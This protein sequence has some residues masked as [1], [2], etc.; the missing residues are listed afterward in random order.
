MRL[1]SRRGSRTMY[2][3]RRLHRN[4]SITISLIGISPRVTTIGSMGSGNIFFFG[5]SPTT[6]LN[7]LLLVLSALASGCTSF[8]GRGVQYQLDPQYAVSDPQFLRSVGQL[9]GPPVVEGNRVTGLLNGDEIF[10]AMLDA[11]R[12][13]Q[14][15]INLE[16]YIYWSGRIGQ[17]FAEVL[18][19]RARAGIEVHVL[20][21]WIGSR[22]IESSLLDM[23]K[24]SGVQVEKYNPLVWYNLA[25]INHRDHR[26]L[27]V[28]DGTVG[29]IGGAGVADI[30]LGH[31]DS[32]NHWR[33]SQFRLEGPAVAQMQA[34]FADN[35]M[36][37]TA[38]VLDGS[39]YFPELKP[40]GGHYAQVAKSSPREGTDSAR[41]MY[42]L[43]IAGA[44]RSIR[45]AAPYFV[46]GKLATQ[47]L[48]DA[49]KR[50][51][52]VELIVPG[53]KI[54]API[55]R[56]AS[57]SKWGP[58]LKAGVKIYEYQPTMF[59]C[60]MMIVDDLWVSVGSANFDSR[61][62][63]LNDEANL[64]VYATDFAVEQVAMFEN[65]KRS[66][67]E[68]SY[69]RWQNRSLAKRFMEMLVAPFHP[70]L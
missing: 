61:S 14:K 65:D 63:R 62:F 52:H 19:E 13:A 21:D 31:A 35:W 29:F 4:P 37:T 34:A 27:L 70:H 59:H 23:M 57:R 53:S 66:S 3:I 7:L 24:A 18:A 68:V 30:W 55:V 8:H 20:L 22:R 6:L 42:L 41:L 1:R 45:L 17:E 9:V 49:C 33:D 26:K 5:I 2:Q 39:K 46:P 47:Q 25:R 56:H 58:L 32:P 67:R 40:V 48:I 36:K 11:I 10:P 16:T 54:D 69:D 43:S 15:S 38:K 44:R 12:A 51:V 64:N 60:K 28:I 50:G